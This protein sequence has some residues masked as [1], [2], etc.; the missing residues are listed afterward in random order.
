M[1]GPNNDGGDGNICLLFAYSYFD[2]FTL[3]LI[4]DAEVC[5]MPSAVM[6]MRTESHV[7]THTHTTHRITHAH[8]HT[9]TN[10]NTHTDNAQNHTCTHTHTHA[11]THACMFFFAGSGSELPE[12][13]SWSLQTLAELSWAWRPQHARR[14]EL[15]MDLNTLSE[16]LA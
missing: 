13:W 3:R 12:P 8:I 5:S 7:Q 15:G 6:L 11:R 1:I 14:A 16:L 10:T 4:Y 2:S 9:H